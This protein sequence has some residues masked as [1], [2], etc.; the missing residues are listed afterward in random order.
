MKK[1]ILVILAAGMGSRYGG[2]KQIDPVDEYGNKIIDFSIYDAIRAGF[3]RVIFIIKKENLPDFK[4]CIG[5]AVSRYVPVDY[6]FQELTMLPEGFTVPEGRVKPWGTAHAVLCCKDVIDAPFAVI[7]ADDFYGRKAYGKIYD[8]L[9]V[10]GADGD[11]DDPKQAAAGSEG[12]YS[13][14]MVGYALKNTLTENGYVSRG[15]CSVNEKGELTDIVER[16]HIVAT[17]NG[18]AYEED[19]VS[20]DISGDTIVSMNL[21]GFTEDYLTEAERFFRD[22]LETDLPKDPLKAEFYLPT[23]VDRLLMQD[24]AEVKVLK[25]DERWFGVT[26]KEDKPFV[27]ESIRKLREAGVY[28]DELW[29][30]EEKPV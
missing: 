29:T 23:V 25:T 17:E 14:A 9:A 26:Y 8:F 24:K 27:V 11:T 3:G 5:D 30:G 2:L 20:V 16:T 15:V 18:A 7:N 19:S 13:F 6:V 28:P 21:W 1:P 10:S 12:K 22:F 4:A